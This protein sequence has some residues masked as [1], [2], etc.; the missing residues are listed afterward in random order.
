MAFLDN[1][2]DI[3]LDAVLTD[4]GR[5]KM[6]D[7]NFKITRFGLGDD[8]INY[9][10][11]NKNHASGSAYY[12]LEILQ[13][14]IFQSTT[15]V[16]NINYGLLNISN[17][18]ILYMPSLKIN[19]L[20][21]NMQ[22]IYNGIYYVATNATTVSALNTFHGSTADQFQDNTTNTV[23]AIY[24]EGG[25]NS[26]DLSK[27]QSNQAAYIRNLR[28]SNSTYL[29]S[30]DNRIF[31]SVMGLGPGNSF[32]VDTDGSNFQLPI[33]LRGITNSSVDSSMENYSS[34]RIKGVNN[35]VY[36]TQTG[37]AVTDFSTILGPGDTIAGFKTKVHDALCSS[38][39]SDN[40]YSKIGS[41]SATLFGSTYDY[42][43]TFVYI[44]GLSTGATIAI[45][46]RVL[47]KT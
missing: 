32:K 2:G 3:I 5:K 23:P 27:T 41:T 16:S 17:K 18:N 4:T 36:Q 43:D 1:S 10:Q 8:E 15:Q 28:L 11:Y 35:G 42:I 7:G 44:T 6:A 21:S 30:V 9:S 24:V 13:T 33:N 37:T 29:L 45:P 38:N 34:Y 40:L 19:S 22:Q 26:S 12:D 47:R 39:T 14:P 31:K 25:I 46:I 20:Q